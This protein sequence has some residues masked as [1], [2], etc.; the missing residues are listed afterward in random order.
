MSSSDDVADKV[1]DLIPIS[2]VFMMFD[3]MQATTG[4]TLRGLGRQK[5]VL[6]LNLCGYWLLAVP[7]GALLTFVADI[8]VEGLVSPHLTGL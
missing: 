7:V 8:G 4:G 5:L 2:C 6:L 3:A 1:A